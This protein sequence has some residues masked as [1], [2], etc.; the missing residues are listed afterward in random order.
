MMILSGISTIIY[1]TIGTRSISL[2]D[3]DVSIFGYVM[4]F[5]YTSQHKKK[6]IVSL[7]VS[8]FVL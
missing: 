5:G 7:M 3:V 2:R 6:D 8:T 1:T 4:P